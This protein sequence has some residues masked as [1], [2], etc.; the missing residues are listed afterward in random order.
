M[1][2]GSGW[3]Q[4]GGVLEEFEEDWK[5]ETE[6]IFPALG[7]FRGLDFVGPY[8]SMEEDLYLEVDFGENRKI[9]VLVSLRISR[10]R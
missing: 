5:V 1:F 8:G 4:C 9:G 6:E 10:A 3:V 2:W 7:V